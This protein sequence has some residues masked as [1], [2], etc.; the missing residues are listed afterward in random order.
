[1]L[2]ADLVEGTRHR[3][4]SDAS[5][6]TPAFVFDERALTSAL[7][8][9][10]ILK[11]QCGFRVLFAMKALAL[12]DAL[13]VMKDS[14][15]GMAVSSG[16]EARLARSVLGKQGTVHLT[17][18]GLR[19]ED[20][21]DIAECCDYVAF[22]SLSQARRFRGLLPEYISCGLRV[23]PQIS[24][25]D[26]PRYDPCR[27][28]TKLGVPL[29]SLVEVVQLYGEQLRG[30]HGL[31]IHSNCDSEDLAELLLTVRSLDENLEAL[32]E[33]TEWVNLG[34]GYNLDEVQD[35][36]PL[37][38]AVHILKSKYSVEVFIEPGA[39]LVRGAAVL[40]A[41]VLDLFD[42]DGKTIAVLDTTVNH[43]P[44]VF[45]YQFA[46]E[47]AGHLEDGRHRYIL[48]GCTCL[49]GDIFGEYA[50]DEQLEVGSRVIFLDAG[51][52]TLV[53]AHMFNG[54]NLPA[55]FALTKADNLVLRKQFTY[56][57]FASRCGV[58]SS[59][60]V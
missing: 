15:D 29:S 12:V 26:D 22:N 7:H 58:D 25:V 45:E 27:R 43:M 34:G 23:N 37:E 47:V 48:A 1:M 60:S 50:F 31:Q 18:P 3:L 39:A 52:Y 19:I 41:S 17:T 35:A 57:D 14:I 13:N 33:C 42:S 56:E 51:A 55:I 54:V 40:V 36:E 10:S 59:A 28:Y 44:E 46:P 53:K 49:A 38:E 9:L 24:F 32:L 16:F 21:R 30:I 11:R 5:I 8:S 2:L 4:L 20:I 6:C